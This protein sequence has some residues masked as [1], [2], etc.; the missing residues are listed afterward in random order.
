MNVDVL[1]LPFI[2]SAESIHLE[3]LSAN[4][5]ELL[6]IHANDLESGSLLSQVC[7]IYPNQRLPIRLGRYGDIAWVKVLGLGFE[8]PGFD[9]ESDSSSSSGWVNNSN[10]KLRHECLRLVANIEIVV[11]PKLRADG[12]TKRSCL[13]TCNLCVFPS[14]KD[15]SSEMKELFDVSSDIHIDEGDEI[16]IKLFGIPECPPWFTGAVHSSTFETLT[17]RTNTGTEVNGR[18][19]NDLVRA[20]IVRGSGPPSSSM[21]ISAR[22]VALVAIADDVP[23]GCIG[24]FLKL[25]HTVSPVY[26]SLKNTYPC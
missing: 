1:P 22:S 8:R 14:N 5:W 4:D 12:S 9:A 3:P 25:D 19:Q 20:T 2:Y 21:S 15:Y 24:E 6:E 23:R 18:D 17:C 13:P 26:V 16:E 7:V 11:V 10:E